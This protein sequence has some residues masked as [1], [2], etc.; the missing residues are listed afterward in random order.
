[1]ILH[2]AGN[3]VEDVAIVVGTGIDDVD[4]V[5][6][7]DG[8]LRGDLRGINGGR[9]FVD[10]DDFANF[11]LVRDGNVDERRGRDLDDGLDELVEA[12]FFDAELIVAGRERGKRATAGEI[13]V[14]ADGRGEAGTEKDAS[15]GDGDSV[16]VGDG[17]GRNG[18]RLGR[19]S[20]EP[21]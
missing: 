13:G 11:L 12:F 8:F 2:D 1:M 3:E 10:V 15:G 5:E 19:R 7:A 6:A 21:E 17:D 14:A 18:N 9:R 20:A 16:F 4:D